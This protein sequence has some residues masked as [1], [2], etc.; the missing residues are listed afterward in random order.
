MKNL[1]KPLANSVLI[2]L[3]LTEA[4]ASATNAAIHLKMFGSGTHPS[5]LAKWTTL[6]ISNEEMNDI[7]KVVNS[8]EE[9]GLFIKEVNETITNKA[10][11]K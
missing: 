3:E 6:I 9:S 1:H 8:L 4:A 5:D 11:A 10:K 7:I 2:P